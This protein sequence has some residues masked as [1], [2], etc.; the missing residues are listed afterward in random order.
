M[1]AQICLVAPYK[2]LSEIAQATRNVVSDDFDIETANLEDALTLLPSLE[3]KGY[4]VLVSRGKTAQL[5]RKHTRIPVVDIKINAYDILGV[6]ADLVGKNR[7][8]GIV[9]Y[10]DIM[11]DC[12]RVADSLKIPSYSILF[13]Q[14]DVEQYEQLQNM[15]R[16]RLARDPIDVM[17]GDTIPQSRF[18]PLCGEFRLV[19]SGTESVRDALEN[20]ITLLN[21]MKLERANRDHL[22]TVLD[23]FEKAVFS[24]DH[25]GLITHANRAATTLFKMSRAEMIGLPIEAIDPSLVIA[26]DTIADRVWEVGQVVETRHGNM[27]CYLY[28]IN[29]EG[30]C[31]SIVFALEQVER[32]YTIEQKIR[33]QEQR[34]S[35][36]TAR[37]TLDEY[38][39]HEP[40]MQAR[41]ELLHKY[42][43]T[44][45]TV[46]IMGESGTGKELLAQGI[47]NANRRVHGPFV[48]INCGALPPSLLESELFGYVEG[49]FTGAL[50]KGKKGLFELAHQGTLFLDEIGELDKLLQ[51]RL[52]RVIQ[53]RELMRLGSEN[54]I[55]VDIR[56]VAASNRKL[57]DMVDSGA[58][59]EDLFY[60]LN[61]LQIEMLPLRRRPNDIIPGALKLLRSYARVH[62][63]VA[64]DLDADLRRLLLDY[65]WPGNFRQLGNVMERLAIIA[66]TPVVRLDNA[67]PVLADLFSPR[68]EKAANC[69]SCELTTGSMDDIRLKVATKILAEEGQSKTHA[70]KRLGVDRTT[71]NRWLK[72]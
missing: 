44:D 6:L 66:T 40:E 36:F 46:L 23:M 51:T 25:S 69:R 21:A 31:T 53:E 11:R 38:V 9:G 68:G 33:H 48:A 27:V 70:A 24:L 15:V 13:E 71:L 22:S 72:Q 2:A 67:L 56:I 42:A 47:H 10:A 39:T 50:R 29:R 37:H 3:E 62:N 17:I 57:E 60:R 45:A 1:T 14:A 30:D 55:P 35:R 41:L 54:S 61:V 52:L 4:Q 5:I 34:K 32:I 43:Q 26:H 64:I 19:T 65:D 63:K 7:R 18:A 16:E 49:A 59:R 58:F 8:V 28:P 12:T 20:A